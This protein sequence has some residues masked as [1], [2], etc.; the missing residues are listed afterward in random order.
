[1]LTLTSQLLHLAHDFPELSKGLDPIIA[2]VIHA[3]SKNEASIR[4]AAT[5]LKDIM[6]GTT[7]FGV[8]PTVAHR[9]ER[10]LKLYDLD[11]NSAALIFANK[12]AQLIISARLVGS[13]EESPYNDFSSD[14]IA[15]EIALD[16]SRALAYKVQGKGRYSK[17][18]ES[19]ILTL[20]Q[21]I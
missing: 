21:K 16:L 8:K 3:Q 15:K 2:G 12:E 5:K 14:Y 4:T 18:T 1:M 17:F 13:D 19:V 20:T 7:I 11:P 6:G 10:Q 9:I